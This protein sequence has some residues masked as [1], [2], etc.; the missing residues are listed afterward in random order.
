MRSV[1]GLESIDGGLVETPRELQQK[2]TGNH[3]LGAT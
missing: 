2:N 1:T 3:I